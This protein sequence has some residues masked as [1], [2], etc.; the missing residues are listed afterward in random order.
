MMGLFGTTDRQVHGA[1]L[2]RIPPR[3]QILLYL[4]VILYSVLLPVLS[5]GAPY[6]SILTW[7]VGLGCSAL[8]MLASKG[9]VKI[10][11]RKILPL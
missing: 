4:F 5:V 6:A 2:D 9:E 7:V 8:L 3:W 1:E 10:S 11:G